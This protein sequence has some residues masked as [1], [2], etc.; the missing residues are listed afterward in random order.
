MNATQAI[1]AESLTKTYRSGDKQVSVFTNLSLSVAAGERLAVIGESGA[2]KSTLLHL[3]GGLDYPTSGRIL[4]GDVDLAKLSKSVAAEFQNRHLGFVWQ[5]PSLLPEFT[6]IEN[7]MMPL[8][9][10]GE[11]SAKAAETAHARLAEVGLRQRGSHRA[12]ELSGGEAQRVA[13]ARA[14]AG[15]PKVLLADEPT[16]SL[17][18]RTGESIAG[19]L[20]Y[21]HSVHRLTSVFVTHNLAFARQCDRVLELRKGQLQPPTD[22]EGQKVETIQDATRLDGG[23]YV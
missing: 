22:V 12:G 2:G 13:L 20:A 9:I 17:D 23:T 15:N 3:L 21:L 11:Q 16:G 19:L 5:N 1:W 4:F 18:H 14:L 10:R 7:V 8:L 6:A